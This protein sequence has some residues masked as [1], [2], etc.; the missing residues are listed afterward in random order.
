MPATPQRDAQEGS[1]PLGN[2]AKGIFGRAMGRFFWTTYDHIGRLVAANLCIGGIVLAPLTVVDLWPPLLVPFLLYAFVAGSIL[3]TAMAAFALDMRRFRDPP[4]KALWAAVRRFWLV[5]LKA[6]LLAA[7]A[8]GILYVNVRFWSAPPIYAQ[9]LK[10]P[11]LLIAGLCVWAAAFVGLC[12]LFLLPLLVEKRTGVWAAWK[13]SALLALDNIG[14]A[15][16]AGIVLGLLEVL[17]VMTL[18]GPILFCSAVLA[19]MSAALYTTVHY[20]YQRLERQAEIEAQSRAK[21]TSWRQALEQGAA[22]PG[23]GEETKP[24]EL[25]ED[26][27]PRRS[28]REI[29]RPW[30]Y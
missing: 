17:G 10:W 19:T 26:G 13:Q 6:H 25:D 20:K 3:Q 22:L 18:A 24:Q 7:G 12:Y 30:E 4:L 2:P 1:A 14:P 21:P 5:G 23:L 8:L 9:Q 29:W 27:E 16:G 11:G 28:F 15:L